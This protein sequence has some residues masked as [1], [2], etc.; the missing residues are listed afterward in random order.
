LSRAVFIVPSYAPIR[1][2]RRSEQARLIAAIIFIA[3]A[4]TGDNGGQDFKIGYYDAGQLLSDGAIGYWTFD[5]GSIDWRT[6]TVADMSG[7]GNTGSL[8][9]MST[10]SS[11]IPGKIGQALHASQNR[12][13]WGQ[14]KEKTQIT[15][16]LRGNAPFISVDS[17][18]CHLAFMLP[19][20]K[21]SRLT[22]GGH[23]DR[24]DRQLLALWNGMYRMQ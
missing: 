10:T 23:G 16:S 20:H 2:A 4:S 8:I 6:N 13:V 18:S 5:G 22:G 15:Q 11:P 24:W 14:S 21:S 12:A 19:R 3:P 7:Q 1:S 9:S 17:G